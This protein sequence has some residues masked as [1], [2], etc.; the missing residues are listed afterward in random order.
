M[1]AVTV[2]KAPI[3]PFLGFKEK[4]KV[5][6]EWHRT[7]HADRVAVLEEC[8]CEHKLQRKNRNLFLVVL[9]EMYVMDICDQ[10]S[11]FVHVPE[12]QL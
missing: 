6:E 8:W 1:H 10:S 4:I 2:L 11:M 7:L 9:S 3:A 5:G 12:Q